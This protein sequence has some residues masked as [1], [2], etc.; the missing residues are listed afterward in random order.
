MDLSYPIRFAVALIG[1]GLPPLAFAEAP[2][3]EAKPTIDASDPNRSDTEWRKASV[4]PIEDNPKLPRVLLIG[5]SI[6]M[7]YTIPLREQLNGKA[8]VHFP[9]ENCH[10]SRDILVNI[11]KYLG[12]KPWDVIQFNCGIHDVTIL[13]QQG[14]SIKQG[15]HGQVRVS[16]QGYRESLEKIIARL[17]QTGAAIVWCSTTPVADNL[18]H[19]KPAEIVRYNS[20]AREVMQKHKLPITDLHQAASEQRPPKWSDGVHFTFGGSRALAEAAAPNIEKALVNRS[21]EKR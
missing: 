4:K 19:R 5:D 16:T 18:P 12:D 9:T 20:V 13:N 8:N 14:R 10:S 17:K 2:A 21:A 15:E 7:G 11:E 3:A 6:T 1:I